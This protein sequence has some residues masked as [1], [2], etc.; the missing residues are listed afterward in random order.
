MFL[1]HKKRETKVLRFL[2]A[3]GTLA[4]RYFYANEV[5]QVKKDELARITFPEVYDRRKLNALY[6]EIP[7][8]DSTFRTL[9]KYF[10]A[11]A[12]L[13]G[14]V[15]LSKAYEIIRK[16]SPR[17]VSE[18]EFLAFAEI[19]R[20]ECEN[21]TIL[22]PKDLHE[23]P[24]GRS[25]FL[26]EIVDLDLF[27]DEDTE[28]YMLTKAYQ[29]DKPWYIPPKAELLA[30]ADPFYQE[31]TPEYQALFRFLS[32]R[33]RLS[34]QEVLLLSISFLDRIRYI[35]P[36]PHA[37]LPD[38]EGLGFEFRNMAEFQ[39][40]L[41]LY[42]NYYNNCRM[43]CNCGHTPTEIRSMMSPQE[44]IPKMI[45][46]GPNIWQA[47]SDGRMDIQEMRRALRDADLPSE[48]L[49]MNMLKQLD[50]IEAQPVAEKIG[51][52]AP[53]PCGSG[54]KYKHCCGKNL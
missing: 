53:C 16:L 37:W 29:Q 41:S 26:W 27:I 52:N 6:R 34:D 11:M 30:Y 46:F 22:R 19:A 28:T 20:H 39:E 24:S 1:S 51:R 45:S 43:Q 17:L 47:I 35:D 15:P 5:Q 10:C 12:T 4:I 44:R 3:C 9:R 32:R 23:K 21:Y 54:K 2:R 36:D 48:E 8:K 50:E 7:L 31:E 33:F 38:W 13:Y 49:R 14:V 40:L 42:R 18:A 25:P